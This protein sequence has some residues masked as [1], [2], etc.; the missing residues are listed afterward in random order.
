[1]KR[2]LWPKEHGAYVELVAP[3]LTALIA[4]PS[5]TGALFAAMAVAGFLANEPLLIRIGARGH[6]L[7]SAFTSAAQRRFNLL[8][9]IATVAA[10]LGTWFA[11]PVARLTLLVPPLLA[12]IIGRMV[13]LRIEKTLPGELTIIVALA[14]MSLPIG[15]AGGAEVKGAL[16]VALAWAAVFTIQT[17][18]IHM[19][20]ARPGSLALLFWSNHSLLLLS[21]IG[22]ANHAPTMLVVMALPPIA[23]ST[24]LAF[25]PIKRRQLKRVGWTF[26]GADILT[27]LALLIGVH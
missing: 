4:W 11:P 1:M 13:L 24:L 14:S 18:A 2:S 10:C 20:K 22:I 3:V 19:V 17:F 15:L 7:P 6:S 12:P 21:V 26:L 23:V 16:T 27:M 25:I 8:I 5:P 9:G